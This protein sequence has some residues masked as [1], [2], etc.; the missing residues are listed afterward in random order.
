MSVFSK[1]ELDYLAEGKLGRLRHDQS[2]GAPH[3]VPLGWTYN[4]ALDTIDVS[5]RNSRRVRSSETSS[6]TRTWRWS[7][8]TCS[9]HFSRGCV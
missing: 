6:G 3:V 1:E 2:D 8:T 5:G 9:H 7:S 4:A